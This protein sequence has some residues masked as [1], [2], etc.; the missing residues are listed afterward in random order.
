MKNIIAATLVILLTVTG[1]YQVNLDSSN[2][3]FERWALE[4]GKN[5]FGDEKTYR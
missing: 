4:Y 5:Y 3:D 1:L 2:S